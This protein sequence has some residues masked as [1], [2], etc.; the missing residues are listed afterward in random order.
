MSVD[1]SSYKKSSF[2]PAFSFLEKEQ[3]EALAVYYAFCRLMDDIA[4][5]PDFPEP[6]KELIFWKEEIVRVF[7]GKPTT[8]LG[9]DIQKISQKYEMPC[10]RFLLLIEGME[11][12]LQGRNIRIG[13]S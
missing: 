6:Q 12:D 2:G 8:Q 10:D 1:F 9:R 5:E 11:A 4:D 13:K 7:Q 3:R